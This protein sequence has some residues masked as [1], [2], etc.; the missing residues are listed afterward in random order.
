MR[1]LDIPANLLTDPPAD[2]KCAGDEQ[3]LTKD[4]VDVK[5]TPVHEQ[6]TQ[7]CGAGDGEV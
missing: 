6:D 5:D 4:S 2:D 1:W 3:L 7:L